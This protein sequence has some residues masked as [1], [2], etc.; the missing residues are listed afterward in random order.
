MSTFS[1][2]KV[3]QYGNE[4]VDYIEKNKGVLKAKDGQEYTIAIDIKSTFNTFADHIKAQRFLDAEKLVRKKEF[5]V[6]E[7]KERTKKYDSLG[8]TEIEKSVFSSK[9]I[10]IDTKQQEKITL[11]II[12]NVLGDDTKTWKSFDE[13]FNA[14]NSNVKKIFPDL[15]KL[16]TWYDHFDLQF[17]Q[18]TDTPKFPNSS[19]GVY[20]YDDPGNFM[21]YISDLVTAKGLS[22]YSKKDS[23]D[24]ADI[25][26][27]KSKDIQKKYIDKFDKI[28]KKFTE[29][30]YAKN[31]F[32]SIREINFILKEAYGKK[33]IVGIS[34]KKSNMKTLKYTEFNLQ[35]DVK[36]QKLPDVAFDSIDLDVS[37]NDKQGFISKTSYVNVV[38]NDK[39]SY[40][41]AFKSNTGEKIGNIT[42]EFLPSSKASAFLGKV[43]KDQL[44]KW[45]VEQI[46]LLGKDAANVYMPQ[47]SKL[48]KTYNDTIKKSWVNKVYTIKKNFGE[49]TGLN[50]FVENLEKSYQDFGLSVKNASAMQMVDFTW[51]LAKLQENNNLTK[52]LTLSYYFAQKKGQIYN[53]GPFGKL[54]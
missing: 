5:E 31:K 36:D 34:L 43:P 33:D 54:Y 52:F 51:I 9:S 29:G 14:P 25:W 45:L 27:V 32:Q 7:P 12:K 1:Y 11:L 21:D 17:R 8:W 50:D 22:L 30:F 53:F 20:L 3:G 4:V 24:P 16:T 39:D 13:M 10:Q 2:D 23:W 41:L 19:Y 44:Q 48:T 37:Y 46:K 18:I 42:Y 6:L 47:G 26:L 49:F 15:P 35:A 38:S 40:K 28:L